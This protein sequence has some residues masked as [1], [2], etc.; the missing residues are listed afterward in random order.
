M[1]KK[2]TVISLIAL[3]VFNWY[4]YRL[5]INYYETKANTH[6][7][8]K[9]DRDQ[10]DESSLIRIRVP[11]NMPYISDWDHFEKF[12]GET[13]INGIHYKYVKRKV[14]KGELV[15]LCI[16]NQ[17]KTNLQAAGQNFFKLV[18]DL[19]QPGAKKDSKEHSIKIPISDY[20]AN[21]NTQTNSI[22]SA[23][24]KPCSV[25][26]LNTRAGYSTTPAQPPE[27]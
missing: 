14:E 4:G 18:N 22:E 5:L 11:L 2:L 1:L 20:I 17:Q 8:A 25:Y 19:Q 6:L 13:E 21:S 24:T 16:P 23:V 10:Y 7:Q 12:E 9:L 15:L 3:L 26:I 27:C